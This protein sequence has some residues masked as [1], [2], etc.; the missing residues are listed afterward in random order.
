M[1]FYLG[2]HVE[3][4]LE[5]C[6]VPLFVSRRRLARRRKVPRA[7]T[8]WALDS[9]GFSELS[10]Y[11]QWQTGPDQY[12]GE[13]RRFQ[14]KIGM[15]QWAAIQDWMCEPFMIA[16]TGKTVL[17]HQK[18]TIESWHYLSGKAPELPWVPVLQGWHA[19]NYLQHVEMYAASGT[20][21]ETLPLVGVGSVC[22]RQRMEEALEI[23]R[24]LHSL[25]IKLHGFGFKI[26]GLW[27]GGS[28]LLESADSMAWSRRA[29]YD[30]PLPGCTHKTCANCM[31]YALLW[32]QKVLN[33][34]E[35]GETNY[36][37]VLFV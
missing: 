24:P 16:K 22:R 12:I 11:G 5:C 3:K 19:D 26:D 1:I 9:G 2:T 20:Q 14:D 33:S 7:I 8:P 25:G 28:Y 10:M 15:L 35:R 37:K 4:W 36:Q 18:R 30:P 27:N 29:R 13:V 6:D 23:L 21:L 32:R 34:I 31:K 17:E